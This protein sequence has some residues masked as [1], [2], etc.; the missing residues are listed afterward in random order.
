VGPLQSCQ[1]C[2]G[3]LEV[4]VEECAVN[5]NRQQPDGRLHDC[6]FIRRYSAG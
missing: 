1:I 6:D 3:D 4:R 2:L 5:V